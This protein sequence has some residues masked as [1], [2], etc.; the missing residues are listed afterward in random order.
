MST[1]ALPT[2]PTLRHPRT[3]LALQAI[4]LHPRTKL[5]LWPILGA[6][7]DDWSSVFEGKTPDQ[8]KKELEDALAAASG[9]T[10]DSPWTE[11]FKDMKPEDVKTALEESRKWES[12]AKG[13][14]T[15]AD[16]FDELAKLIAGESEDEPDADKLKS[17]LT[18]A[19]RQARATQIENAV[20]K[21][22]GKHDANAALLVD[23]RT[24]MDSV[25]DLDPSADDFAS[26][27]DAAIKKAVDDND[28]FKVAPTAT[29]PKP[30]RQQ[31]TP[32]DGKQGGSVAS[33]REAYEQ[34]HGKKS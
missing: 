32:S 30:V 17:E 34:R 16:Q 6:A 5:P 25:R 10:D 19:Q 15:K 13:N 21:R 26:K 29:R 27:L 11:L 14:K 4:G 31:G 9:G 2:H 7:E 24:F 18:A 20:L 8:V 23:S 22:H 12:R 33:G 28:A 1:A 3:G